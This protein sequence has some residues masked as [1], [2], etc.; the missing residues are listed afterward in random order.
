MFGGT[1]WAQVMSRR[2]TLMAS[3]IEEKV[4]FEFVS[5]SRSTLSTTVPNIGLASL[6]FRNTVCQDLPRRAG[7]MSN[8]RRLE[9]EQRGDHIGR[10]HRKSDRQ[11]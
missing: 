10:E 7:S 2:G 3:T 6:A 11:S 4:I 8:L 1:A 5:A 9:Y